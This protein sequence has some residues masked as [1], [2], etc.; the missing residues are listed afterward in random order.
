M[1]AEGETT[2]VAAAKFRV[3][4][5]RIRISQLRRELRDDWERFHGEAEE[6][7]LVERSSRCSARDKQ[8]SLEVV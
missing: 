8:R 3:S 4:L 5:G 7:A 6:C 2:S 1:L